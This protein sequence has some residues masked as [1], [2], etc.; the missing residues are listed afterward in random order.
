MAPASQV[1]NPAGS[2]ATAT[3]GRMISQPAG[4]CGE[5]RSTEPGYGCRVRTVDPDAASPH[6]IGLDLGGTK[7]AGGVVALDA[8]GRARLVVEERVPT[9]DS[10]AALV[11]ALVDLVAHLRSVSP[12]PP[13]AVGAGIAG[14]IGLDG[15]AVQAANT[16]MVV[17]VDLAGPL[18]EAS[19]LPVRIDNDANVVALA[20]QRQLAPDARA[21]VAV[22]FGTGIGGGLVLDGALWRG[23]AGLAGEPGHMV[24]AAD[25][26]LC[27]CG[28][29]GCWEAVASGTALGEA[30]RRA[31]ADGEAPDLAARWSNSGRLDG[32]AVVA[33]LRAG[34]ADAEAVWQGWTGWV[35]VGLANL[36]QLIDPDVIVLGGGVSASGELL[37]S[38]VTA[39]L[40]AMS[41]AW[42]HRRIDLRCAPGGPLAGVVGAA[43][44]GWEDQAVPERAAADVAAPNPS[45]QNVTMSSATASAARPPLQP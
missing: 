37:A 32:Q 42:S 39:H 8:D 3:P 24:V 40:E 12:H 35:A 2:Q 4:A 17:G 15:I 10:S 34:E 36:I 41:V 6:L 44:I 5:C 14:H 11:R 27:R 23:A 20:A 26:P 45:R 43:L 16:P 30:A 18:R 33:G 21:L 31:V 25:G 29:R 7:L 22:T 13:V 19:G 1:N 38:A 28:Q 9:P